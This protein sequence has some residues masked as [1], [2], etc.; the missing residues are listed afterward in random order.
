MVDR[1]VMDLHTDSEQFRYRR[2]DHIWLTGQPFPVVIFQ[3]NTGLHVITASS[4]CRSVSLII[5]ELKYYRYS[6]VINQ[7][8]E[9]TVMRVQ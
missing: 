4:S 8:S 7:T 3:R 9:V 2:H 1:D 6:G 5:P